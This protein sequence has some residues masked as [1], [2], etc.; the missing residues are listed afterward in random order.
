MLPICLLS[1]PETVEVGSEESRVVKLNVVS[2][3]VLLDLNQV[4]TRVVVLSLLV[5]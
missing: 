1:E 2:R 3:P 4:K 5:G